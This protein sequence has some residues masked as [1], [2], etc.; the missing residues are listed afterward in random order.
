VTPWLRNAVWVGTWLVAAIAVAQA[1]AGAERGRASTIAAVARLGLPVYC[2][3]KSRPD[4]ALTFDDGPG[5]YSGLVVRLLQ[6][7]H[8]QATFFLVGKELA[9]WPEIPDAERK[10]G[11]LGDHSWSHIL[12]PGLAVKALRE[13]LTSTK[14]AIARETG[15][16]VQLFRPPY[17][18]HDR[19]TDEV[20]RALGLADILWS[21]DSRDSEGAPWYEIVS[22]VDDSLRPGS[23]V[24]MHENHGQTIR[25]L[26]YG[27]LPYLRVHH[28]RAVTVPE[29]LA[30]DPPTRRQL[31][32][33]LAA[34]LS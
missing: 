30:A 29:L 8:A 18:A 12:L 2:G 17:G 28:L 32:R 6:R 13:Q 24:L 7:A 3:G 23:I 11:A 1:T 9:R 21:I 10:V 25:A 5:P 22:N 31:R 4:V 15:V 19:A 27:I 16:P 34:C 33:G 26:K 20:A 14:T